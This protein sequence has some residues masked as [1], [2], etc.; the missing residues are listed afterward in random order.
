M[1]NHPVPI[2]P[3]VLCGG[4]GTRLWPLS[5]KAFPKQFVPLTDDR[6]LLGHT[7]E[8]VRPLSQSGVWVVGAEEHRFLIADV[9]ASADITGEV[10]LEP[11]PRNTAAAMA[12][13]AVHAETLGP[14][15]LMLFCP[16]DHHIPDDQAFRDCVWRGVGAAF[17]GHIVTFG[18]TPTF[19]SSAFGYLRQGQLVDGDA[20][21]VG[22]FIEKPDAAEAA[23]LVLQ[24]DALWNAGIFL[25]KVSVLLEAFGRHAPDILQ[26]CRDAM[27]TVS[28]E[29]LGSARFWR[30]DAVPFAACRSTSVDYAIMEKTK[31]AGIV[32]VDPWPTSLVLLP[33][34][35]PLSSFVSLRSL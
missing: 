7:V 2:L 26:S 9:L 33:R 16:S 29:A 18:I 34:A 20:F 17:R 15:Q 27:Q 1:N 25:V 31:I 3:V 32:P 19:P 28:S 21:A 35:E 13:A 22:R 30:P 23:R 14:E 10:M 24:G 5:R 4:S 12:L 8:R 6:S 11:V